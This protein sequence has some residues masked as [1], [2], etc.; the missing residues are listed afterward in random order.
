MFELFK[1]CN[2]DTILICLK[3]EREVQRFARKLQNIQELKLT[4]FNSSKMQ[5]IF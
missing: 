4:K 1:V 2:I 5:N 3:I